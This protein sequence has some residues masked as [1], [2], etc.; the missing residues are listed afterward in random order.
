MVSE[1][2][3]PTALT[4]P[5]NSPSKEQPRNN[6]NRRRGGRG[7]EGRDGGDRRR[8]GD[9]RQGNQ[10]QTHS[11]HAPDRNEKPK[12][13]YTC[14]KCGGKV[15]DS[16]KPLRPDTVKCPYCSMIHGYITTDTFTY[17]RS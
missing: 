12:I 3:T 17:G 14:W 13:K 6:D 4:A 10:V 8:G 2:T 5:S 1:Q 11:Q 16:E 7:R 9:N 15:F